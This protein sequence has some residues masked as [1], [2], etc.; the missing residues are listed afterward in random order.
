VAS[1]LIQRGKVER[2]FL[3]IAATAVNL[4]AQRAQEAGQ[5]RAVRIMKVGEG[6]PAADAGLEAEDLLLGIDERPV[7]SVDDVQR[8]LALATAPEVRLEVLRQGRR[9]TMRARTATREQ[10]KAA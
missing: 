3:G 2:R 6:T 5:A 9:R 8:L 4:P 1:L 10:S 7:T